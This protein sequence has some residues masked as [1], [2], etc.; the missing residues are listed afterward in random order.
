MKH[1]TSDTCI[2]DSKNDYLSADNLLDYKA[3]PSLPGG[4]AKGGSNSENITTALLQWHSGR[5]YRG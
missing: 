2:I 1:D 4:A 3:G 5:P